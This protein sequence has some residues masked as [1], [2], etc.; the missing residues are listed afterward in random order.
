MRGLSPRYQ[1]PT[2]LPPASRDSLS[3]RSVTVINSPSGS[4]RASGRLKVTASAGPASRLRASQRSTANGVSGSSPMAAIGASGLRVVCHHS[5]VATAAASTNNPAQSLPPP[6][7]MTVPVPSVI[8]R[9][10]YPRARDIVCP[11]CAPRALPAQNE[12]TF[13]DLPAYA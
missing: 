13:A 1:L 7:F 5:P 10:D 11:P 2:T 6:A 4:L 12:H 3:P 8:A 9:R